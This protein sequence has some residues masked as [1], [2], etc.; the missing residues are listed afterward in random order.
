MTYEEHVELVT[1]AF[2]AGHLTPSEYWER[3]QTLFLQYR[4]GPWTG[5]EQLQAIGL[6]LGI[7]LS[8]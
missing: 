1:K 5:R 4:E 2:D 7:E 8:P 6:E 3:R